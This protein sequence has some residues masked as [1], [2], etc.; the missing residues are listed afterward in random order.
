MPTI[1][2]RFSM[3]TAT[4]IENALAGSQ[5]E[6][7]PFDGTIEIGVTST[8]ASVETSIF[9]GPD[10]LLEP[11]SPVAVFATERKP[12]YPDDFDVEDEVAQGDRLK[13]NLVNRNAGTAVVNV[14]LRITPA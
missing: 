1:N 5:Y 13:I 11:G 3:G 6:F 7:A 10:V 8:V 4:T 2:K 14:T 9:S 12:V